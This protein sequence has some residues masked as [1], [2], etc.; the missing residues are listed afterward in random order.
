MREFFFKEGLK[1]VA[2]NEDIRP[3]T[4]SVAPPKPSDPLHK[5][6]KLKR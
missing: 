5:A 2:V 1:T 3:E 4:R 6:I